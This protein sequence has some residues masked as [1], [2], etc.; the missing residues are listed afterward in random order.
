ME[1]RLSTCKGKF[2]NKPGR[3]KLLDIVLSSMSMYFLTIFP[4]KKW[5]VKRIDIIRRGFLW[6]GAEQAQGGHCLVRWT[7]VQEP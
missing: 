5:A 3:L 1:N 4:L 7:R 2:L 6:K